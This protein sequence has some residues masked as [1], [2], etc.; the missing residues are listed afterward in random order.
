MTW[1]FIIL[2]FSFRWSTLSEIPEMCLCLVIFSGRVQNLLR[3]HSHWNNTL[4]GSSK[5][6][7]SECKIWKLGVARVFHQTSFFF[8]FKHNLTSLHLPKP[9]VSPSPLEARFS[10][11]T[12]WLVEQQ[13][14]NQP[15]C[16][17]RNY[18][19]YFL[20]LQDLI[21]APS[22][23]VLSSTL[24][25]YDFL[26]VS[27]HWLSGQY[28]PDFSPFFRFI[29]FIPLFMYFWPHWAFMAARAFLWLLRVRA[30]LHCSTR[31]SHCS[32]FSRC[33][34]GALGCSNFSSCGTW[35]E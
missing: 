9:W 11:S 24:L 20:S 13:N 5:E 8:S 22:T 16:P 25:I 26:K 30:T 33:G 6:T 10:K 1:F 18:P 7:V 32:G 3:D 34:A 12:Y 15:F 29:F 17:I 23:H 4:N 19:S 2:F 14:L 27:F 28:N 31:A 21:L 35:A